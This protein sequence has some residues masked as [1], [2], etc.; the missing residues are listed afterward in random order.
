[1][2][3]ESKWWKKV[4]VI[5]G[6]VLLVATIH[7]IVVVPPI[8]DAASLRAREIAVEEADKVRA[9]LERHLDD[10]ETIRG[11]MATKTELGQLST[12]IDRLGEQLDRIEAR[13]K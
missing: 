9:Q 2:T 11:T 4:S 7:E 3:D 5:L 10:V 8:L 13:I 1:V 12:A 6:G